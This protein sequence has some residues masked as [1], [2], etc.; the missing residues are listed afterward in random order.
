[1]NI[2]SRRQYNGRR[3]C[4]IKNTKASFLLLFREKKLSFDSLHD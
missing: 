4:A 1:V 3:C 2:V